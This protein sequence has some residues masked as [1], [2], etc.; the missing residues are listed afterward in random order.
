MDVNITAARNVVAAAEILPNRDEVRVVYIGSVAM[1]S[2]HM[3]PYHW[4]RTGD[5]IVAAEFDYYGL[6]KII[7]EK[8]FAES[9]L[10]HWVSLRQ[11]GILHPGLIFKGSDP[12]SFHVPLRGVLE[13]ATIEDSGRLMYNLCSTATR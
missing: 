9:N 6:S 7:G 3:E 5:P 12:I 8:I 4:G 11:S 1:T 2:L 13:W 10:R